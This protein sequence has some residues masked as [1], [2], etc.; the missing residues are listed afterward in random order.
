MDQLCEEGVLFNNAHCS[1]PV[2]TASRNSLLSE[3]HPS[4]SG[5]Y[6]STKAMRDSY[7]QVMGDHKMLPQYFKDNGYETMA[8]GKVFHSGVSDYKERSEDFWDEVAPKYKVPKDLKDRGNGY[9][10]THFY[11]MIE[12]MF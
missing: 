1:Q 12:H 6:G 2:C 4:T 8:V 10:G 11:P 7:D 3:I 5:W 9:G